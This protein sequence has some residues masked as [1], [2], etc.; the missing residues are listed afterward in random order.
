LKQDGCELLGRFF[1]ALLAQAT[2]ERS[3]IAPERRRATFVYID[4]AQDYFDAGIEQL[5]NQARK[6]K[7][8]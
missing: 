3:V 1:I 4:E 5:L 8:A 6:Y 2:Q 7:V